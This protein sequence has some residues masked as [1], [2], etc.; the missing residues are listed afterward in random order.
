MLSHRRPR[1]PRALG[2]SLRLGA[3]YDSTFALLMVAAPRLPARFLGL[4]LPPL[5]SGAFYL[6]I[7]AVLLLML[8]SL[9]LLAAADPARHAGVVA[10]ATAGRALGGVAFLAAALGA[11]GLSGLYP[12]AAADLAFAIAHASF[13]RGWGSLRR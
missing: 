8:S 6:W 10:V 12:L 11:P 5:P 2:W 4:P 3:L 9:Y 7:M 13:W 1:H